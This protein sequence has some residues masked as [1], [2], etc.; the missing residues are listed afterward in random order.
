MSTAAHHATEEELPDRSL[1]IR[2]VL[3]APIC[4]CLVAALH[5]WRVNTAGQTPWK[6]GSFG[7][8]STIDSESSRFVH[9]YALTNDGP[10]PLQ[11]PSELEKKVAELRA[12]PNEEQLRA[13]ADKLAR[14]SWIDPEA[15]QQRLAEQ[16]KNETSATPLTGARLRELRSAQPLVT[17]VSHH[18]PTTTLIAEK[19]GESNPA[20][21]PFT[22][23]RVEVWKFEMPAATTHLKP[24]LLFSA[25]RAAGEKS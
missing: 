13:L 11:I 9:A 18:Q 19:F 25:T 22:A 3:L 17:N 24:R 7:M 8:F 5:I 15:A 21:V 4:L 16:L 20:T 23:V 12:A 1:Q 10:L 14:R 2:R 6:G